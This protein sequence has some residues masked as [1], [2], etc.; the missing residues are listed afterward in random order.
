[1][2]D[3]L[4]AKDPEFWV[5]LLKEYLD[6]EKPHVVVKGAPSVALKKQKAEEEAQ[7]VSEQKSQL[8][9]NGLRECDEKLHKAVAENN[10]CLI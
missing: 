8:G 3:Q 9:P 4:E 5:G 6:P 10:V 7:R 2:L 1:M